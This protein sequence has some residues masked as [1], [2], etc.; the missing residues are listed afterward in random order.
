M[1]VGIHRPCAH[2]ARRRQAPLPLLSRLSQRPPLVRAALPLLAAYAPEAFRFALA[3]CTRS[4]HV[5]ARAG[6]RYDFC[7][8][9]V[10]DGAD[11][12][13][14]AKAVI[15]EF[16]LDV[17]PY[18]VRLLREAEGGGAPVPLDSRWALA[19]QGVVEGTSV[20]IEVLPPISSPPPPAPPF[21]L[22]RLSGSQSATKVVFA[23]GADAD[24]LAKAVI[25]ELKL[26]VAPH[27]VRLLREAEGGG[28]PVPL[29]S[30]EKLALQGIVVGSRVLAEEIPPPP[31]PVAGE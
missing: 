22:A 2:A 10:A 25:T 3:G 12:S 5:F 17:A 15:T 24:D 6:S 9:E 28:A 27:C 30:L 1:G 31:K 18:R 20:M 14:L 7:K 4:L 16:K 23:P 21:V 8:V 26:G 19:E 29:G 11:A 13:D